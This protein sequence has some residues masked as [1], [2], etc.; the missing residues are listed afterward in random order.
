[1]FIF[2]NGIVK[3][4][5]AKHFTCTWGTVDFSTSPPT[6]IVAHSPND[7]KTEEGWA[8]AIP[9]NPLVKEGKRKTVNF[10]RAYKWTEAFDIRIEAEKYGWA[11]AVKIPRSH[12]DS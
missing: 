4:A 3:A 12:K 10:N 2:K 9:I 1:M 11:E 7:I 8:E 6:E 5:S